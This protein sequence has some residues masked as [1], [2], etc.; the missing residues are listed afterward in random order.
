MNEHVTLLDLAKQTNVDLAVGVVDN[1]SRFVPEV[2][3]IL[4]RPIPGT[5]YDATILKTKGRGAFRDANEGVE[6]TKSVY[7]KKHVECFI[8]D[9]QMEADKA[10]ADAHPF[11]LN[12]VLASEAL[13][14]SE[15][16]FETLSEQF[17]YGVAADS[18]GFNGLQALTPDEL[19]FKAG[20]AS[21]A[22]ATA[23]TSAY[24][25]FNDIRG[26]HFVY[27]ANGTIDV[28]NEWRVQKIVRDNKS[29][30]AYVNGMTFWIGLQAM[31]FAIARIANIQD[32][33]NRRLT[34]DL[35]A[36]ALEAFPIRTT[37]N[38]I[39]MSKRARLTLQKSRSATSTNIRSGV[40][41]SAGVEVFAPEPTESNG[42][43]I[44]V[45]EGIRT[46]E[47]VVS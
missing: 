45:T 40:K 7:E 5:S 27:G 16:S 17:Y 42:I 25:V 29:L 8:F 32:A 31:P 37:P 6:T 23:Q 28:N 15:G 4:G 38:M 33:D 12:E 36:T 3:R 1:A 18:K 44:V 24:L 10:V 19:L 34:D 43:P 41:T 14:T 2:S 30:T 46:N 11:G 21:G 22:A 9:A 20:A 35:I 47:A 39:L 26:L 13:N